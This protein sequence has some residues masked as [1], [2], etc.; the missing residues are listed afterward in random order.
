MPFVPN[1]LAVKIAPA[2][3]LLLALFATA[4]PAAAIAADCRPEFTDECTIA[5]QLR[6]SRAVAIVRVVS[7]LHLPGDDADDDYYGGD[8][9]TLEPVEV[10]KGTVPA[11]FAT[12]SENT[13]GRF[14]LEVGRTYLLLLG[15]RKNDVLWYVQ[16]GWRGNSGLLADKPATL[17]RVRRLLA[18][19]PHEMTGK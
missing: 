6:D 8:I 19:P 17:A 5:S 1:A 14:P 2:A 7:A 16:M 10:L 15:R 11:R 18:G 9:Y 4:P 3:F 12:F 13:S